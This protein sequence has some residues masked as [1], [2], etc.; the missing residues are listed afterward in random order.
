MRNTIVALISA[1]LIASSL[2]ACAVPVPVYEPV[3][4]EP[5]A[6]GPGMLVGPYGG[7]RPRYN[8][9]PGWHPGPEGWRCFRNYW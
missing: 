1:S 5:G 3:A 9:P 6:C 7:C 2:S 4:L 8:C